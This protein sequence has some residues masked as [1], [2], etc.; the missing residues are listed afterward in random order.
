MRR[1]EFITLLGGAAVAWPRS[2]RTQQSAVRRIGILA[3][4]SKGNAEYGAYIAALKQELARLGWTDGRNIQYDER[5]T[6]DNMDLVRSNAASLMASKPDVVV[7]FGGRV[8]PILLQNS[9]TIP[10]VAPGAADPVGVGWV[11]SLA[12]PG[13][14]LTGFTSFELSL[15]TKTLETLKQIVPAVARVALI[16]N[17]DNPN[18]VFYRRT[19]EAAAGPLG[20]TPLDAPIHGFVDIDRIVTGL[21]QQRDTGVFFAPDITVN[22]LMNEIVALAAQRSVPAVYSDAVFVRNGGLASYGIDRM[23]LFVRAAG[24]VDRILRGE[25]P[26]DLPFQQPTKYMLT[27][28]LKAAKALGLNIPQ[29]LLATADEVIE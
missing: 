13:G 10:I 26:G 5:W 25:K 1:R 14:N 6:T 17:S 12:R 28:N 24:Y 4:Y 22:A 8:I 21:T 15:L 19:F 18:T 27:L 11:T 29:S 2:A 7:A 9:R 3:P 23:D 16:Y 20:I